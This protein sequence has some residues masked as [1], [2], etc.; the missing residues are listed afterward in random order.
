[1]KK[2]LLLVFVSSFVLIGCEKN[3]N[4]KLD[5]AKP[6]LV[7]EATIENGQAPMVILT[8]STGYFSQISLDLLTNSFVHNADVFV[9]NGTLTHK[10]KEYA[11][12]IGGGI[13]VYYYSIDSG[14]LT[15]AFTGELDHSYSLKIIA[16]GQEYTATTTIPKI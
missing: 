12:A 10:L 3:I 4:F 13:S 8:K 1:M 2:I 16:E 7:V 5:E 11:A 9:S 6:K 14:N 15:T